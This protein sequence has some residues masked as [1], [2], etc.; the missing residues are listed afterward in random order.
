MDIC[1]GTDLPIEP[2]D[3]EMKAGMIPGGRC[4]VLRVAH[5]THNLEPAALYLYREWLPA[6]GE[7][8]RDFPIYCRRHFSVFPNAPVHEVVVELFLPLK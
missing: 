1:V 4:A 3:P 7:D 5:D 8:V 6:S 2:D